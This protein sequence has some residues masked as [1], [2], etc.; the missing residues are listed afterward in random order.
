MVLRRWSDVRLDV[1]DILGVIFV[2]PMEADLS[3]L[4]MDFM[5]DFIGTAMGFGSLRGGSGVA[6]VRLRLIPCFDRDEE[7]AGGG[8]SPYGSAGAY[9]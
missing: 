4:F 1:L 9:I 2:V 6:L 3:C 7:W 5:A 8:G